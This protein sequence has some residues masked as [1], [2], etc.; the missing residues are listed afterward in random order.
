MNRDKKYRVGIIVL[1]VMLLAGSGLKLFTGEIS[2][3]FGQMALLFTPQSMPHIIIVQHR[4]PALLNA[5]FVGA[6]LSLS[7]YVMQVVFKN[8][9]AGP[10]ILGVASGSGLLVAV[11]LMTG[12]S[13][14]LWTMGIPFFAVAGALSVSF[15]LLFLLAKIRQT[16][17]ILII[18][19]LIS[20]VATAIISLLQYFSPDE[21]LKKYVL[22]TMGNLE[23]TTWQQSVWVAVLI[24]ASFVAVAFSRK[25]VNLLLLPESK[26]F[27]LGLNVNAARIYLLIVASVITGISV[28]FCGPIGFVGIVVPHLS[29]M[30]VGSRLSQYNTALLFLIGGNLVLYADL[31]AHLPS[32]IM[33]PVNAILAVFGIPVIFYIILRKKSVVW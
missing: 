16:A 26:A 21:Q 32:T 29:A 19:I 33:L 24:T 22:W 23:A 25:K 17:T 13:G 4:L 11:F 18:G 14:I 6:G 9:L 5:V 27:S 2:I 20:S 8:A 3:S 15:L 12:V 28:A 30:L 31:L 10:Y 1:T 7:G